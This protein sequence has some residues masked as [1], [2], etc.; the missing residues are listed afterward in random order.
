MDTR[1]SI[2]YIV[3]V[4][5]TIC[6]S[7]IAYKRKWYFAFSLNLATAIWGLTILTIMIVKYFTH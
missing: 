7:I 3:A 6:C 1:L 4:L 5:L 2:M